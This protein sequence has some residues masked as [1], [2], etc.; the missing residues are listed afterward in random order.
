MRYVRTCK[1]GSHGVPATATCVFSHRGK[2]W[3]GEGWVK[4]YF[5]FER[6]GVSGCMWELK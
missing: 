2:F 4:K 1:Y 3:A 5:P 6:Y